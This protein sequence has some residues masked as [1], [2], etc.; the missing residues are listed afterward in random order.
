M[1]SSAQPKHPKQSN[2]K[3]GKTQSASANHHQWVDVM[4]EFEHAGPD[5]QAPDP[6][7]PDQQPVD[8]G[9]RYRLLRVKAEE[10]RQQLETWIADEG[11]EE[12]VKQLG[13]ATAF[14]LLFAR[15]TP[16]AA[17]ALQH[18]PGVVAVMPANNPPHLAGNNGQFVRY[19]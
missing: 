10:H 19:A 7:T 1:T 5:Q 15:V 16:A 4:V 9:E 8:R 18:A 6:Q 2:P 13:E 17:D 3:Q 12:Q 14:D 11:L